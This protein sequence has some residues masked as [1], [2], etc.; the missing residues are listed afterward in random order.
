MAQNNCPQDEAI[1]ILK[2]ASSGRNQKLRVCR[3]NCSARLKN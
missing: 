1:E 3:R 2:K